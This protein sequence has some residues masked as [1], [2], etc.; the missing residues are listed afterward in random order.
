ML[1]AFNIKKSLTVA[2]L[3]ETI[4]I[5]QYVLLNQKVYDMTNSAKVKTDVLAD[6]RMAGQRFAEF[7]LAHDKRIAPALLEHA[8]TVSTQQ[9]VDA[10]CDGY[11][12]TLTGTDGSKRAQ[13]SMVR[14]I[15]KVLTA[16]DDKLNTYHKLKKP[17]DG[18][19][20][21]DKA[22]LKTVGI[23]ALSKALRVPA[24]KSDAA[25][26]TETGEGDTG[27]NEAQNTLQAW[28]DDCIKKG[29]SDKYGLTNDE[30]LAF[31]AQVLAK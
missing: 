11:A 12:E 19:K 20:V 21:L 25:N 31:I 15:L 18:R 29:H 28:W 30:M 2:A 10:F 23:D 16:T 6:V 8:K 4:F 13:K 14:T 22:M 26:D 1:N 9:D 5:W 27:T 3:S 17:A 7:K 24:N